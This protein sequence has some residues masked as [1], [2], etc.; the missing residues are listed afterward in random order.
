MSL[1]DEAISMD[2][3]KE[4]DETEHLDKSSYS[5]LLMNLCLVKVVLEGIRNFIIAAGLD[6]QGLYQT[7]YPTW[8]ALHWPENHWKNQKFEKRISKKTS[9]ND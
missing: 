1:G 4:N 3:K 6:L 5:W 2:K 8:T 9:G 7:L